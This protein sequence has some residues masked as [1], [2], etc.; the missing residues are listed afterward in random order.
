MT[1]TNNRTKGREMS[2]TK[3]IHDNSPGDRPKDRPSA[4]ISNTKDSQF[5]NVVLRSWYV[6]LTQCATKGPAFCEKVPRHV[7]PRGRNKKAPQVA[8]PLKKVE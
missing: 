5:L 2:R 4:I 7:N 6:S 8:N 1:I 3:H